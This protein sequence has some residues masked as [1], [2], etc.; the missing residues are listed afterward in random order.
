[1]NKIILIS[2]LIFFFIIGLNASLNG[3]TTASYDIEAD[4]KGASWFE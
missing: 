3:F 4:V 1:M 2:S